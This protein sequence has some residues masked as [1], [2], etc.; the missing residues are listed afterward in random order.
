M[1]VV[2][3]CKNVM[4]LVERDKMSILTVRKDVTLLAG[5]WGHVY[6]KGT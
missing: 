4:L 3:V 6:T 2:R 5:M 1:S